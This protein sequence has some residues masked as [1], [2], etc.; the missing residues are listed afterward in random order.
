MKSA[1]GRDKDGMGSWMTLEKA[2]CLGFKYDLAP[3]PCG[4]L[5]NQRAGFEDAAAEGKLKV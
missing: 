4:V 2:G 3:L 5:R 1:K